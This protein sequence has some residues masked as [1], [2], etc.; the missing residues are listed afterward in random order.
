M[1]GYDVVVCDKCGFVFADGIPLQADF[2][3]YYA[4]MSKYE[5]S[6]QGGRVSKEYVDYFTK[7]FNFL[8]PRV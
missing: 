8:A 7:I 2:D 5:F 6:Y 4:A 1:D 3:G